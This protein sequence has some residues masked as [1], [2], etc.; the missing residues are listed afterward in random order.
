MGRDEALDFFGSWRQA[1]D[2]EV[3]AADPCARIGLG[4]KREGFLDEL[5]LDEGVEGIARVRFGQ[6]QEGPMLKAFVGHCCFIK[7]S[8]RPLC[9]RVDPLLDEGYLCRFEWIIFGRH[10]LIFIRGGDA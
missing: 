7:S 10:S 2:I 9:T 4:R 5:F 6:R 8:F 3:K 1:D